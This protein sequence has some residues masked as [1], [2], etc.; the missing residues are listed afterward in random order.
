[1]EECIP[2]V[3]GHRKCQMCKWLRVIKYPGIVQFGPST[4][5]AKG[6]VCNHA[7]GAENALKAGLTETAVASLFDISEMGQNCDQFH[8]N[9]IDDDID[10]LRSIPE[11]N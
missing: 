10:K 7:R 6:L 5:N 9:P 8:F 2:I 11:I 3:R 4:N 1:M